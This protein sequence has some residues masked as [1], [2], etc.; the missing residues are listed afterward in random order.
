[1]LEMPFGKPVPPADGRKA[2]I[3]ALSEREGGPRPAHSPAGAERV[4]GLFAGAAK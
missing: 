1:M 3:Q 2:E 4:R